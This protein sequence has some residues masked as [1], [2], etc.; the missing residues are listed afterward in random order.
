MSKL[1]KM[2]ASIKEYLKSTDS[3]LT[4][5]E[6]KDFKV[7]NHNGV[8]IEY[9]RDFNKDTVVINLELSRQLTPPE[10]KERMGL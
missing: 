2:L 4:H 9:I 3:T 5:L 8:S 7:E 1:N 10:I 6:L